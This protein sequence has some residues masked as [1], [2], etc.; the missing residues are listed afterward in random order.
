MKF[1]FWSIVAL[2]IW[3]FAGVALAA[4]DLHS[5]AFSM[6]ND[7]LILN[8]FLNNMFH[9]PLVTLWFIGF[10]LCGFVVGVSF[11]FC[12]ITTLFKLMIRQSFRLKHTLLFLMHVVFI[13]II[14]FHLLSMILGYKKGHIPAFEGQK[15]TINSDYSLVIRKINFVNDIS[16][17]RKKDKH[18]KI[19]LSHE[20][21][22]IKENYAEIA[23]YKSNHLT[24][25]GKVYF[26]KPLLIKGFCFTIESF[27][28]NKNSTSSEVGVKMV[29]AK[30]PVL[31]PF[32]ITYALA[33]LLI[34]LLAIVTWKKP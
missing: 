1:A 30:N 31:I 3:F 32:F 13:G 21:F 23:L 17:L 24:G 28:T 2:I 34:L 10:C 33:I 15:I 8:W 5:K 12:T 27:I 14:G 4:F 20:N 29:I 25:L 16:V 26:L 9:D 19:R 7:D 6:M 11:F 22:S 18:S